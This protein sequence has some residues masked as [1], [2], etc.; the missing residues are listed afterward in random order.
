MCYHWVCITDS[1]SSD[2]GDANIG[3]CFDSTRNTPW[4]RSIAPWPWNKRRRRHGNESR[5]MD[6]VVVKK[7]LWRKRAPVNGRGSLKKELNGWVG[8]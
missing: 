5:R 8:V 4:N 1:S 6:G 3:H 7:E 2:D